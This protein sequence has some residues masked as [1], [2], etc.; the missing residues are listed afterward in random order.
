MGFSYVKT[1]LTPAL[2]L[3]VVASSML[4]VEATAYAAPP[5]KPADAKSV[6][7]RPRR[8]GPAWGD[9]REVSDDVRFEIDSQGGVRASRVVRLQVTG[10]AVRDLDVDGVPVSAT[11]GDAP[12]F[13][14]EDGTQWPARISAIEARPSGVSAFRLSVLD[15]R[16]LRRGLYAITITYTFDGIREGLLRPGPSAWRFSWT[17]PPA[18]DGRDSS[19]VTVA[20]PRGDSL[21]REVPNPQGAELFHA[22]R[23]P[24]LDEVEITRA[25]VTRG[26]TPT[27][28]VLLDA[29]AFEGNHRLHRSED[30]VL[31]ISAEND[32]VRPDAISARDWVLALLLAAVMWSLSFARRGAPAIYGA[33]GAVIALVGAV[34]GLWVHAAVAPTAFVLVSALARFGTEVTARNSRARIG[35]WLVVSLGAIALL[36]H[37]APWSKLLALLIAAALTSGLELVLTFAEWHRDPERRLAS[38]GRALARNKVRVTRESAT[39]IRVRAKLLEGLRTVAIEC[40][41]ADLVV[42]LDLAPDA[43]ALSRA[44]ATLAGQGSRRVEEGGL[45]VTSAVPRWM[46]CAVVTRMLARLGERRR[47]RTTDFQGKDRRHSATPTPVAG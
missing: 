38:L 29:S 5:A 28:T 41:G 19:K 21:P 37:S 27:W 14:R 6:V 26:E 24:E 17:S 2:A 13:V 30:S 4:G 15:P 45:V 33:L 39:R 3:A 34:S 35:G 42:R 11:L 7:E 36:V 18:R 46:A 23:H 20:L 31:P 1:L 32:T 9:S 10:G 12:A 40:S 44:L 43:P 16:G 22:V 8:M 25:H 47:P